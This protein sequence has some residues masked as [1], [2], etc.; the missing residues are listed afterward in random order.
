[1]DVAVTECDVHELLV[2]EEVGG[3][4]EAVVVAVGRLLDEDEEEEGLDLVGEVRQELLEEEHEAPPGDGAGRRGVDAL[5]D[6]AGRGLVLLQL[7]AQRQPRP[8]A[9]VLHVLQEG[10]CLQVGHLG[11][12]EGLRLHVD[13]L[14]RDQEEDL[15]LV[16]RPVALQVQRARLLHQDLHDR[17]EVLVVHQPLARR[18][19]LDEPEQLRPQLRPPL[20]QVLHRLLADE[21]LLLRPNSHKNGHPVSYAEYRFRSRPN[22][23]LILF[24]SSSSNDTLFSFL[25]L[26]QPI[27]RNK[28]NN[29]T[30]P[31]P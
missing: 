7:L 31:H 12:L 14:Q 18:V 24:C 6:G 30:H 13:A 4:D 17:Q 28:I 15:H 3:L 20:E 27:S 11:L 21:L 19:P 5:Q 25:E 10:E 23:R 29:N 2:V 9:D 16:Q 22:S 26:V 8:H 1:M